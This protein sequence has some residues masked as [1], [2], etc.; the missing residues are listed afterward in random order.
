MLAGTENGMWSTFQPFN[1]ALWNSNQ[2]GGMSRN[3]FSLQQCYNAGKASI[4]TWSI[5]TD[6][7]DLARYKGTT[8]KLYPHRFHSYIFS[9]ET[10]FGTLQSYSFNWYH[11]AR[12]ILQKQHRI[13]PSLLQRPNQK[14]I[15]IRIK[16]PSVLTSEWYMM[17]TMAK[18]ALFKWQ[19]CFIDLD[20]PYMNADEAKLAIQIQGTDKQG[21][22]QHYQ[23][24][25]MADT[26]E[27]NRIGGAG[28][29]PNEDSKIGLGAPYW[30]SLYSSFN[31]QVWVFMPSGTVDWS[32][33]RKWIKLSQASQNLLIR[34]G[35]YVPKSNL[36]HY[37]L[38]FTYKSHFQFGGPSPT[39]GI[40]QGQDP[41]TIPPKSSA[42]A[43][44]FGLE[45]RDPSKV[46]QG[47]MHP[48]EVR[49]GLLTKR[50]LARLVQSSDSEI[51]H[52][53]SEKEETE[54]SLFEE[55]PLTEEEKAALQQLL[56][57]LS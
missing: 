24:L 22:T 45:A 4:A 9:W 17:F 26:G 36:G 3:T 13:V 55:E 34:T 21:T 18:L 47:V 23:Y 16:P 50:G 33:A 10:D 14:A 54:H 48:W 57:N 32:G 35:P 38:G 6:G 52:A 28:E 11:P 30:L 49:R 37:S 12:L 5:P 8:I 27:D 51:T 31:S 2:G 56:G 20:N 29:A 1:T 44:Q 42:S 40:N 7:M 53:E 41:S 15:K 19:C 39:E 46:G 25:W 43:E